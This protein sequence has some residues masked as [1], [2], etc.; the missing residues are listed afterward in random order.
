VLIDLENVQ[1]NNLN[2][3]LKH[4]FKILVFVSANQTK[5]SYDMGIAIQ[6][7]AGNGKIKPK[8]INSLSNSIDSF[9]RKKLTKKKIILLVNERQR[10]K[11]IEVTKNNV[12]YICYINKKS[13]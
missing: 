9:L 8:T 13:S 6:K 7:F 10:R 5:I 12:S 3:L 2:L 11:Y 1:P 4:P